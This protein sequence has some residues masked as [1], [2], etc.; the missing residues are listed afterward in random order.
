MAVP[1]GR[2]R[3][4]VEW[5]GRYWLHRR[6]VTSFILDFCSLAAEQSQ[7]GS[8]PPS[9]TSVCAPSFLFGKARGSRCPARLRWERGGDEVSFSPAGG[10][11]E[12]CGAG[13]A[14]TA[15]AGL[16]PEDGVRLGNGVDEIN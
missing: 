13:L 4:K 1:R 3:C 8:L 7:L 5:L 14:G 12:E 10:E 16:P 11:C 2:Q 15:E 9:F 6:A